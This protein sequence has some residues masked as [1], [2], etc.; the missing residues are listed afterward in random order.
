MNSM[1]TRKAATL[2]LALLS[3]AGLPAVLNAAQTNTAQTTAVRSVDDTQDAK[4]IEILDQWIEAIGGSE[5]I[6]E[7]KFQTTK[8]TLSMPAAGISGTIET[9]LQAP[10]KMLVIS[11]IPMIGETRQG[12]NG[13]VV[14][15]SDPMSGPRLLPEA[16]AKTFINEANPAYSLEFRKENPVIEYQGEVEFDGKQAHKIRLVNK[17][18]LEST[19]YFDPESHLLRGTVA[20]TPTP[21]GQ[22][23]VT[24][25]M[26]EYIETNGMMEPSKVVQR[27]GPQEFSVTIDSI[28]YDEID[29][30]MFDLPEA[31]K[32]L[33]E[34]R[35]EED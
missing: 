31:I 26:R 4:A 15:S 27:M 28:S 23:E 2:G 20:I 18:G 35:K 25:F 16:E 24:T 33:V 13:N 12:M 8:A 17:D 29:T 19:Q 34:A 1:K 11:K 21:M 30:S 5:K 22:V 14:W 3:L 6:R 32:A 7:T 10:D 9:Y